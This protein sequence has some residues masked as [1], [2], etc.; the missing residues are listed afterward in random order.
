MA[1]P[2]KAE[3]IARAEALLPALRERSAD[4]EK[5]R[6]MSDET[7]RELRAAG[8]PKILQP[9]RFAGYELGPDTVREPQGR[10][11]QAGGA[12]SRHGLCRARP[13]RAHRP[14]P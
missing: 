9:K 7:V 8:F 3:L 6:R 14:A 2:T 1:V 4:V 10:R 12:G 5:S 13:D 11:G